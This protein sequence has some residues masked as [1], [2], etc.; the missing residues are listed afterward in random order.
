MDWL[1]QALL[2]LSFLLH[3]T[4]SVDV[5]ACC[6]ISHVVFVFGLSL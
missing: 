5:R 3:V 4:G 2:L 1:A 6:G